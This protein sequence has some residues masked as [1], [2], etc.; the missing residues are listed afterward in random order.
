MF[1][2]ILLLA[3]AGGV[4]VPSM[5]A[6][7]D[8][9]VVER[10]VETGCIIGVEE[11]VRGG[12]RDVTLLVTRAP[13]VTPMTTG[14]RPNDPLWLRLCLE[15]PLELRV[16]WARVTS[17]GGVLPEEPEEPEGMPDTTEAVPLTEGI[18]FELF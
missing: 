17:T 3:A 8:P 12:V 15:E 7:K 11:P 9:V 1:S 16:W 13:V 18:V 6:D 2:A 10:G 14:V 5:T 4:E